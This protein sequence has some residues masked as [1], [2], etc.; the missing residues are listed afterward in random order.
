MR[1][2]ILL[3]FA[4]SISNFS[5]G[6][7]HSAKDAYLAELKAAGKSFSS[8][9]YPNYAKIYSLPEKAVS[10]KVDSARNQFISILEKY[11]KQLAP[12]FATGQQ[13]EIKYFFDK[14]LLDFP[15]NHDTYLQTGKKTRLSKELAARLDNNLKDFNNPELLSISDFTE[16]V[17]G[18]FEHA[19]RKELTNPV[20]K[21]TDNQVLRVIW[22]LIPQTITNEA[23]RE[24]WRTEYLSYHL[25]NNGI[26]NIGPL[27]AEYKAWYQQSQAWKK[28]SSLYSEDSVAMQGHLIVPYK[29]IGAITLNLHVFVPDQSAI[30]GKSPVYVYFHGGSWTE[31]KPDW[32]FGSCE[33]YAK[34]G[35][36]GVSVEYRIASRHNTLPFE[37]VMDARSAIRWLK[38]NAARF[39]ID[40]ARIVATGNSSGGHLVLTTAL[41]HKWN[42]KTD[43]M[44][45]SPVPAVLLV[46]SGVYDLTVDNT[47]WIT[48]N[49]KNKDWVKQISPNHLD[50]KNMPPLFAVHGTNDNNCPYWTAKKFREQAEKANRKI[51]FHAL[52]G[53]GHFF[54]YDQKFTRQ[55]SDWR[56]N[57]LSQLGLD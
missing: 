40:T 43:D 8:Y 27:L 28:I 15:N 39:N 47:R 16:Y 21:N 7:D 13:A 32:G 22:K 20:Y 45:F 5:I 41:A 6:Q 30:A 46:N 2:V 4:L 50:K 55:I 38:K 57:F 11:K 54:W 14:L 29:T 12:E 9:F 35:W 19:A 56:K 51:E 1:L 44:K 48:K 10:A 25:E 53:A 23:C 3:S 34:K 31:G 26:K 49:I 18:Y 33:S 17:K 36:V 52:E 42:E 24:F 37:S